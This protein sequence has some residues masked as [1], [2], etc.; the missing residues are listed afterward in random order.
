MTVARQRYY[1]SECGRAATSL[2][3]NM[4]QVSTLSNAR[5]I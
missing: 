3:I 5:V 1:E 4:N 2:I